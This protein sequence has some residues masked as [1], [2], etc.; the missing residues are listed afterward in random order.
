MFAHLPYL[1]RADGTQRDSARARVGVIAA[2]QAGPSAFV[3]GTTPAA[4]LAWNSRP[5]THVLRRCVE[6]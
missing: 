4:G 2:S 3:P 1:S 5:A 6:N